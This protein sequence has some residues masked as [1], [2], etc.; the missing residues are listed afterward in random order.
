MYNS[1]RSSIY[2]KKGCKGCPFQSKITSTA[3]DVSTTGSWLLYSSLYCSIYD[4]GI[5]IPDVGGR[6]SDGGGVCCV[7]M[8][9]RAVI[10]VR[11]AN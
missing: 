2:D 6:T 1:L 10:A 5:M 4:D 9:R 3:C 8:I 7:V 11:I